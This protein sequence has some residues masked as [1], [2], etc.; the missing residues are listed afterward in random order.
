MESVSEQKWSAAEGEKLIEILTKINASDGA[1]DLF[2]ITPFKDAAYEL[3]NLVSKSGILQRWK[4]SDPQSWLRERIGTVHTFQGKEAEAVIFVLGAASPE[5]SS[6][7]F[8][9]GK[10]PNLLNVAVTRAKEVFYVIGN[11]KL[12]REAGNFADLVDGI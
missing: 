7:R 9:A 6:S 8:W 11:K 12:W 3:R 4:I 5:Q 2:I 1:P 10:K